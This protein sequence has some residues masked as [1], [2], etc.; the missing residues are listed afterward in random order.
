MV[1]QWR[2]M[3]LIYAHYVVSCEQSTFRFPSEVIVHKYIATFEKVIVE[4]RISSKRR[5]G[6]YL[7]RRGNWCGT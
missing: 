2:E 3:N 1:V 4:Y 6:Y 5:R 7:F